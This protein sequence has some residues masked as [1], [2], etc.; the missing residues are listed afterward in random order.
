[1]TPYL[2]RF[3]H[4]HMC[5]FH[6]CHHWGDNSWVSHEGSTPNFASLC[7]AFWFTI[8]LVQIHVIDIDCLLGVLCYVHNSPSPSMF[9]EICHILSHF[10]TKGFKEVESR[11]E[12][13]CVCLDSLTNF[14]CSFTRKISKFMCAYHFL[15]R[16]TLEIHLN[17]GKLGK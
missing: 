5:K 8:C 17:E 9:L 7:V 10:W 16:K 15:A 4:A 6:F 1:M 3:N 13:I 11:A 2:Q 12:T 14:P